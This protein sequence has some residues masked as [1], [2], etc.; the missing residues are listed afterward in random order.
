MDDASLT[1][2][3]NRREKYIS[4]VSLAAVTIVFL[5]CSSTGSIFCSTP[6]FTVNHTDRNSWMPNRCLYSSICLKKGSGEN[7]RTT[8]KSLHFLPF[9][10]GDANTRFWQ[11]VVHNLQSRREKETEEQGGGELLPRLITVWF[12]YCQ[13]Q[14][15]V[16]SVRATISTSNKV[17]L[18]VKKSSV[19]LWHHKVPVWKSGPAPEGCW[20]CLLDKKPVQTN[21]QMAGYGKRFDH[22]CV[23]VSGYNCTC[24]L[25]EVQPP[26]DIGVGVVLFVGS[27]MKLGLDG[28]CLYRK[29]PRNCSKDNKADVSVFT[30]CCQHVKHLLL[31]ALSYIACFYSSINWIL[32]LTFPI[33]IGQQRRNLF[34]LSANQQKFPVVSQCAVVK[35][36]FQRLTSVFRAW[37]LA[38]VQYVLT[39]SLSG[40]FKALLGIWQVLFYH[41]CIILSP[42][43]TIFLFQLKICTGDF[44]YSLVKIVGAICHIVIK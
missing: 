33:I 35:N 17:N 15:M 32:L 18:N 44:T 5:T 25:P 21:I 3:G 16:K 30:V 9:F 7:R 19:M 22:G 42:L 20:S 43:S 34:L 31:F 23:F 11:S 14:T 10:P 37:W 26:G 38:E 24:L 41:Y 13:I 12:L 29:L 6:C 8:E 1:D 4:Q 39:H 28:F 36:A 2:A 27:L 40:Q